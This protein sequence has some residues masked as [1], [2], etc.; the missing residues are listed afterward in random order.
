MDKLDKLC[1]DYIW[2]VLILWDMEGWDYTSNQKRAEIHAEIA[3]ILGCETQDRYLFWA[4]NNAEE[5]AGLPSKLPDCEDW[6]VVARRCGSRLRE[7][8]RKVYI[9]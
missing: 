4:L 8:L 1:R 7:N 3:C 6:E 9:S 5:S 2:Y